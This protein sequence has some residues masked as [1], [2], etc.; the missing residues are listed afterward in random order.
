MKPHQAVK[1]GGMFGAG[2]NVPVSAQTRELLKG[3]LFQLVNFFYR[4]RNVFEMTE[5]I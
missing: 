5:K 1:Q 3:K 2:N 4:D